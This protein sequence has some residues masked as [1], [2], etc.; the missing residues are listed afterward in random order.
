MARDFTAFL[1][2]IPQ[3]AWMTD[4]AGMA[5][6]F[7][8]KS[9]LSFTGVD[10]GR[11]AGKGFWKVY[12]HPD[13]LTGLLKTH[14]EAYSRLIAYKQEVRFLE[15]ATGAWRWHLVSG[16]PRPDP[17]GG[18]PVYLGTAFDI[19]VMKAAEERLKKKSDH[20]G[21]P[22]G[23]ANPPIVINEVTDGA[24]RFENVDLNRL[25]DDVVIDLDELTCGGSVVQVS[26]IPPVEGAAAMLYQLFYHLIR[27]ALRFA[28]PGESAVVTLFA[29]VLRRGGMD[30]VRIHLIDNCIGFMPDQSGRSFC[31]VE[32]AVCRKIVHLHQGALAVNS[33][34]S[35][36]TEFIITLPVVQDGGLPG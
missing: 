12:V 8:N 35:D 25:I 10:G 21:M 28:K 30:L 34:G 9:L 3:F 16:I 32:L 15:A 1:N 11:T 26:K 29:H 20:L 5:M 24:V 19:S 6:C 22:G 27:N 14:A 4:S 33:A 18:I 36:G 7:C 23:E 31:P 13:D 2:E 17:G